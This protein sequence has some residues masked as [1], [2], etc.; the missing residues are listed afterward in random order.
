MTLAAA[1]IN[2][3]H[4]FEKGQGYVALSRLKTLEGLRLLGFN[5]QALELDSLAIKA[6]RR[7]QELSDE[8]ETHLRPLILSHSTRPLS[9]TVVER[10]MKLRLSVMKRKLPVM[11]VKPTMLLQHSMKHVNCLKVV[12]KLQISH[13]SAV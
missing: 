8:A 7:F 6:D 4:T 13:K 11:Q 9:V 5:E 3:S 10:S 12:M 1:E 2:L